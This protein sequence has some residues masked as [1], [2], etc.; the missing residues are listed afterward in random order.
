MLSG[1]LLAVREGFEAVLVLSIVI[2]V[3]HK[4]GRRELVPSV[5]AGTASAI[6]GSLLIAVGLNILGST[7]S[8]PSEPV[9][10][11]SAL[12]LAAGV[13][14]WMNF[15]MR[16]QS[17]PLANKIE[18]QASLANP[19]RARRALFFLS[20]LTV[21]REGAELSVFLLAV[22]LTASRIQELAGALLGIGAA[23]LL[24]W[25]LLSTSR[26]MNIKLFFRYTNVFMILFAAGMVGLGIGEFNEIGWIP[27]IVS[28]LWNLGRLLPDQSLVGQILHTL[29][30]YS[31][32][33]SLTQV[34]A[35]LGYL[36]LLAGII[37]WRRRPSPAL[38]T[39][40]LSTPAAGA[41]NR[42]KAN[43]S[44]KVQA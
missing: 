30:G 15:W 9:F 14:T 2:G 1:F 8:G 32:S 44:T 37:A 18:S 41:S 10:E 3:L 31:S 6:V 39:P 25:A 21:I 23:V 11:G 17:G 26:R 43:R 33:P 27:T 12:L 42:K 22:A 7:F 40:A 13:L 4:M 16:K 19:S 36:G 29:V 5:W 35:Y 24:G 38:S 28:P 34:I 20:F